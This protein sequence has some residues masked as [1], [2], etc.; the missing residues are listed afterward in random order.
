MQLLTP[1]Y[2][3]MPP[4]YLPMPCLC[5]PC[6][7]DRFSG[8]AQIAE[9]YYQHPRVLPVEL[10]AFESPDCLGLL[11]KSPMDSFSLLSRVSGLL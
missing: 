4:A 9:V 10:L 7:Q 5:F 2:L 1:A 3:P 11:W 6:P 8:L